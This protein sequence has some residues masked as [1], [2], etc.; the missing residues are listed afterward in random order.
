MPT[1]VKSWRD[2]GKLGYGSGGSSDSPW[3]RQGIFIQ[4]RMGMKDA[5]NTGGPG[6][7]L[8]RR[9]RIEN[10]NLKKRHRFKTVGSFLCLHC[11]MMREGHDRLMEKLAN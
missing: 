2:L 6:L 7:P 10:P 5:V 1:I 8:N 9:Q 3:T 4:S 11:N